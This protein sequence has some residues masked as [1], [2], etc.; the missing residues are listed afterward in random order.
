MRELDDLVSRRA[1]L[2]LTESTWAFLGMLGKLYK[3]LLGFAHEA[4]QTNLVAMQVLARGLVETFCSA[5]WV[6]EQPS[7][8]VAL[9]Q[10]PGPKIGRLLNAGYRQYPALQNLYESLSEF[11]HPHR[12]GHLLGFRSAEEVPVKGPMSPFA[13]SVPDST[14][15][16]AISSVL[17]VVIEAITIMEKIAVEHEPRLAE[18][19]IMAIWCPGSKR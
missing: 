1:P 10:T 4:T 15:D 18:G 9:V 16:G 13:V 7:R 19:R 14:F 3:L 8:L 2:T 6:L 5:A 12:S 11:A 17:G